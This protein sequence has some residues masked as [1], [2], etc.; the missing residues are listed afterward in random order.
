MIGIFLF[1]TQKIFDPNLKD[2]NVVIY[3]FRILKKFNF[4][5]NFLANPNLRMKEKLFS[6]ILFVLTDKFKA[7]ELSTRRKLLISISLQTDVVYRCCFNL[8]FLY[9]ANSLC[10]KY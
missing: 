10:L 1:R 3:L 9:R 2:N 8:K 6:N 5:Q 7:L 4:N